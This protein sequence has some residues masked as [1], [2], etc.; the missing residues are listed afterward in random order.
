M[1]PAWDK[2]CNSG[3]QQSATP[4]KTKVLDLITKLNLVDVWRSRN[5]SQRDYTYYS[6]RHA[7]FSRIDYFL[8]DTSS[9]DAVSTCVI[10]PML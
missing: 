8:V 1:D 5:S 4:A 9:M 3:N 10:G 6:P 7:V 2:S